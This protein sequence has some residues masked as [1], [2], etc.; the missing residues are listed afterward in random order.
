MRILALLAISLLLGACQSLPGYS[1]PSGPT[2]QPVLT[3]VTLNRELHVRPD[4]ASVYIQSGQA[5]L[6]NSAA[7]YH[8]HCILELRTVASV[9]RTVQPDTFT[10]TGIH[11]DRFMAGLDGLMLAELAS[12]GDY[13][14]V[15]STTTL[16]LHSDRQPDVYRL[17][18]QQLDEPFRAHHVTLAEMQQA[19][20][21]VITLH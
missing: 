18:C 9:A 5:R 20:G 12:G 14:P 16:T 10:V 4:Y 6:T 11:R 19:L 13:N 1:Y 17:S 21:D 15:M 7:E 3:S 2:P 8:P